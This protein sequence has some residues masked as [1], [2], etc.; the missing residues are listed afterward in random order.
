MGVNLIDVWQISPGREEQGFWPE[1]KNRNIIAMGWD[2]LGDLRQYSSEKDIENALRKHYPVD[3]PKDNYP[4]NDINSIQVF[5]RLVKKGDIV[6]AKKGASKEIYGA[7]F[8]SEFYV[9]VSNWQRHILTGC[10]I[11]VGVYE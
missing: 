6:V 4:T 9:K 10:I 1:F 2:D 5:S 11:A 7:G 3:Y 8:H